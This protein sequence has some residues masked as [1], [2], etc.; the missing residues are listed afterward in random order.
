M[1]GKL[2]GKNNEE[3]SVGGNNQVRL[4]QEFGVLTAEGFYPIVSTLDKLPFSKELFFSQIKGADAIEITFC[5]QNI[6]ESIIPVSTV[7]LLHLNVVME[8]NV[9]L[10][11]VLTITIDKEISIQATH[12]S[13]GLIEG[14]GTFQLV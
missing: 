4:S 7:K 12:N 9:I 3:P 11:V 1:F 10:T 6:G 2:F 8:K 5:Q 13:G 14:V